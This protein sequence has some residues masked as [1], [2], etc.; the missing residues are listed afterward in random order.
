[1]A[2]TPKIRQE[3]QADLPVSRRRTLITPEGIDLGIEIATAGSRVGAFVLDMLMMVAAMIVFSLLVLAVFVSANGRKVPDSAAIIWILGMFALENFWFIFW[4]TQARGATPGKRVMKI[5]VAMR[6]GGRLT[7]DAI[8]ARNAMRQLELF[9]PLTMLFTGA[10]EYGGWGWLAGI[11]WSGIFLLFPLFNRDRLR[12]GDLLGGT[13]VVD[14]PRR[15]LAPDMASGS[16]EKLARFAFTPAQLDAY[17]V[18]EL[19]VL[20]DVLRRMDRKT[21]AAVATR[22]RN[23]TGWI[24]EASEADFDFL[25]AYYAGLRQRLEQRLLFGHRRKD[26]FD[27]V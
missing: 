7:A 3:A 26:K 18:M 8:F 12:V 27:H 1:M 20:E 9:I 16:G 23:K 17:G 4:E 14:A 2:K 5:R 13:W 25:S 21:M 22:I 11:T 10:M 6:N 24:P 19:Q 15:R